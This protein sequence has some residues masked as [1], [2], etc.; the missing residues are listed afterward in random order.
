MRETPGQEA[1][2]AGRTS[3]VNW[4]LYLSP[5]RTL[6]ERQGEQ[7]GLDDMGRAEEAMG[8]VRLGPRKK[9]WEKDKMVDMVVAAIP[10]PTPD[11][12]T[13]DRGATTHSER[14]TYKEVLLTP[15]PGLKKGKKKNMRKM[16]SRKGTPSERGFM[17]IVDGNLGGAERIESVALDI[18]QK[19]IW[20]DLMF[21]DSGNQKI[22]IQVR[23]RPQLDMLLLRVLGLL[24]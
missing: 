20:R 4:W 19:L 24:L 16:T 22:R 15:P 1:V 6:E 11:S 18:D 7:R 3:P 17:A 5:G 8:L 23:L 9:G 12:Q 2:P 21:K 14:R 10:H 13:L